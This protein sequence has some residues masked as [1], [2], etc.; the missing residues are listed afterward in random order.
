VRRQGGEKFV[1]NFAFGVVSEALSF[2]TP[3][4]LMKRMF[5]RSYMKSSNSPNVSSAKIV[6]CTSEPFLYVHSNP[7][8]E[9]MFKEDSEICIQ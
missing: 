6:T 3:S 4:A 8:T 1:V 5:I 9:C 2:S 7:M